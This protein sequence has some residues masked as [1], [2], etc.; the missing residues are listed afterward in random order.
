[1]KILHDRNGWT[2][3]VNEDI[4]LLTDTEL[5]QV[6]KIIST[7]M[8][9]VFKEQSLTLE[10]EV[11]ICSVI[12]NLK[13]YGDKQADIAIHPNVLRVTGQK[14]SKGEPGLFGH[15]STLDWHCNQPSEPNRKPLIWLYAETGSKG[16]K[17]SWI[18]MIEAYK[19]LP[20]YLKD[21]IKDIKIRCGWINGKFG[22]NDKHFTNHVSAEHNIIQTNNGGQTGLF[23]P[24]LQTF[25]FVGYNQTE[26]KI[27][28]QKI[29][30]CILQEKYMYHHYWDD[31]DIVISDQWLSLHKRWEFKY[32]EQRVLH[33]IAFDYKN[34]KIKT[35]NH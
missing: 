33:R 1:M 20:K 7:N 2:V 5:K 17:T 27:L 12:G 13:Q 31:G 29:Q 21:E 9:V 3:F 28:S 11:R 15:T 25:G 34:T 14:N 18:N 10:D 26:Y 16:S 35:I 19:D 23:Y 22:Y 24:F 8:T 30:D 6:A 4:N 32:M